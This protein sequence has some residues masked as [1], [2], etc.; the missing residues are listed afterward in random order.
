MVSVDECVVRATELELECGRNLNPPDGGAGAGGS[1]AGGL[2]VDI[3][4]VDAYYFAP[5]KCFAS[6]GGIFAFGL[7]EK[8]HGADIYSTAVILY[9]ALSGVVPALL[10][11]NYR[12]GS[13]L[14]I[15]ITH[16][17]PLGSAS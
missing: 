5:Q 2:P 1:G 11:N 9:E 8:E 15:L 3:T 16:A 10:F 6:D 12:Y 14:D 4:E 17:P 7:S 13:Y